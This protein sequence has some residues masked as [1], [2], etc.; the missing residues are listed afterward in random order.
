MLVPLSGFKVDSTNFAGRQALARRGEIKM[1][2]SYE[3]YRSIQVERDGPILTV[4]LNRPERYNAIDHDLHEE[5]G[6]IFYEIAKDEDAAVVVLTGSGKAFCGG[7]DLKA[8]RIHAEQHGSPGYYL[9]SIAAKRI[10]YSL[11]ELE[12]PVIAK[13][14]GACIGLGATIALLCDLIYMSETA[15]ISDPHVCAG[16]VAGD[17]G[18]ALWPQFIGYAKAKEYLMTGDPIRAADAERMGLVNYAVPAD[19]LDATVEAMARRLAAGAR[20]AIR[21]TKVSMNIGLQ[22]LMHSTLDASMAYEMT[23]MRSPNHQEAI[24]AFTSGREPNFPNFS[25]ESAYPA[26]LTNRKPSC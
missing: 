17:G 2:R 26:Y 25:L 3:R 23:T 15:V 1:T 8:M 24:E 5:L 13:V 4:T 20:D 10:V 9:S 16:V 14:N 6:D 19:Q 21:W 12:K 22:Q 18:A 11:L 7:G